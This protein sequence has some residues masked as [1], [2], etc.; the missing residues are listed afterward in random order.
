MRS[1]QNGFTPVEVVLVVVVVALLA[2]AGYRLWQAQQDGQPS[3]GTTTTEE[4]AP[5]VNSA[6]DLDEA[7]EF[8]NES[9]IDSELDTSDIDETLE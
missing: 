7:E 1:K 2:F 4:G 9:D 8:L 5:E 3:T 6:D